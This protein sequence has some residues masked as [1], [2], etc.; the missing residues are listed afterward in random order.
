MNEKIERLQAE[1]AA[2]ERK[3]A[4]CNHKFGKAIYDPETIKVGYGSVQDG[5]GSDPHWSYA[6]YR[7]EKKDRWSR[8]C[9]LCNYVEYTYKLKP[10]VKDYEPEF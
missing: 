7:D 10:I 4:N 9:K 8:K 6:G 5:A 1:I 2:E 3:I